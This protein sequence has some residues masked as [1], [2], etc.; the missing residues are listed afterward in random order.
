MQDLDEEEDI[1]ELKLVRI[2]SNPISP[3]KDVVMQR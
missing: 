3:A 1:N 2:L